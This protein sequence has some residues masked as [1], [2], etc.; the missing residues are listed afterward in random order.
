M[1]Y[2]LK[3]DDQ[4][5][6]CV[7]KAMPDGG[8]GKEL[9]CYKTRAEAMK[10]MKAL[11]A[12]VG[13]AENYSEAQLEAYAEELAVSLQKR[14]QA[15]Y[16]A[17]FKTFSAAT[18]A[19]SP[20]SN[21]APGGYV[22]DVFDNYAIVTDN[23]DT[24]WKA[25]FTVGSDGTVTFDPREKWM[26]VVQEYVE[27]E[28]GVGLLDKIRLWLSQRNLA[29]ETYGGTKRADLKDSDFVFPDERAFPVMSAQDVKDAVSSWGRYKGKHSFE[30]F[31]SKLTA[32]AKRK[33]FE[34]SLPDKWEAA[35]AEEHTELGGARIDD[36]LFVD[37][38][39]A[40]MKAIDG[41]AAGTFVAM[42]GA[43][44]TFPAEKLQ[45]YVDRTKAII[46]S[47]RTEGGEVVGLPIDEDAHD[48]RGGAGWIKDVSLDTVRNVIRF[49]VEWTDKGKEI[50]GKNVRRFFSPTFDP[51][52]EAVLGGSLTNWP[53]SRDESG[54]I[55]LKPVELSEDL[56]EI[57]VN[58]L[59]KAIL[60]V[61]DSL[62]SLSSQDGGGEANPER[63]NEEGASDMP[64]PGEG[65]T[66]TPESRSVSIQELLNTPAA[67][68]ELGRLAEEKAKDMVRTDKRK[69]HV[70][71]FASTLVGGTRE[72]PFGLAVPAD[73]VVAFLLSLTE[74]QQKAAER[75]LTKALEAAID[76]AEHGYNVGGGEGSFIGKPSLPNWAK[77]M[78]AG[79]LQE[80]HSIKEFFAING[81]ELGA[82][83]DY[84]LSEFAEMEK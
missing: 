49:G 44:V 71:E 83:K 47:T 84:N 19:A 13:D 18:M 6:F 15:V 32:L 27:A 17:F 11:Y 58:E 5:R 81:D 20:T 62:K 26:K 2:K 43:R 50:I 64:V 23:G 35:D 16:T 63:E 68:Q 14:L 25:G 24:L 80:G 21:A 28:E 65:N 31:Q 7:C 54:A 45:T 66:N 76:F 42:N 41:L 78:L 57:D 77:P 12:N 69:S 51:K 60:S 56:Q 46:E 59:L 9:K 73:E 34:A 10:Y 1:P 33:G 55:V 70:V 8:Y 38:A 37:M 36:F 67:I 79:W 72:K 4:G 52:R 29:S 30:E 74:A 53:A 82:A 48:H 61:H 39:R 75:L 40:D 3:Q 22:Q